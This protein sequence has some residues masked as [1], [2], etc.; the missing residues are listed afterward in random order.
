MDKTRKK[1]AIN[2]KRAIYPLLWSLASLVARKSRICLQ[3]KRFEFNPWVGKIL[4]RKKWQPTPVFLSGESRGQRC[5]AGY[6][7]WGHKE[8]GTTEATKHARGH[9]A[10]SYWLYPV[11]FSSVT[12]SCPT[13]CDPMNHSTPGLPVHHQLSEST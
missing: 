1:G 11:Q 12:Q 3:C 13:L 7:L 5:L 9:T 8:L 10:V 6:S 2:F 4:W